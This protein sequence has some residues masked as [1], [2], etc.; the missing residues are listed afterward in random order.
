MLNQIVAGTSGAPGVDVL[1]YATDP[2]YTIKQV[3]HKDGKNGPYGYMW[4]TVSDTNQVAVKF[5]G[6]P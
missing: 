3:E 1:G 4:V 6:L 5:V 2:G